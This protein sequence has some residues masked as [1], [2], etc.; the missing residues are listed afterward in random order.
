MSPVKIL[1]LGLLGMA[2]L[3]A[4]T[5]LFYLVFFSPAASPPVDEG[6]PIFT[7]AAETLMAQLTQAAADATGT[8][9]ALPPTWTPTLTIQVPTDT[10]RPTNT[11]LVIATNTPIFTPTSIPTLADR[12]ATPGTGGQ[13]SAP[14]GT[15]GTPGAYCNAAKFIDDVTIPDNTKVNPGTGFVKTWRLE[16]YGSCTWTTDY[17][18]VFVK[19]DQMSA[20]DE[21]PMPKVVKPGERVDISVTM[22]APINPGTYESYWKL[23]DASGVLF[24]TG[25]FAENSIW[26]IIQVKE[27]SSGLAFDF[28][29]GACAA[30]WESGAGTLPCPGKEGDKNGFVIPLANPQLENRNEDEPG[31]LTHPEMKDNGFISG[32]YPPFTVKKGDVFLADIGC[33]ADSD[34]CRVTFRL[35]YQNENDAVKK[36]GEWNEVSDGYLTSVNIDLSDLAGKTVEFILTVSANGSPTDDNAVWFVPQ[37]QRD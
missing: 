14:S 34:D 7:Q 12:T 4:L 11:P 29:S 22:I 19:G 31:L 26:A 35:D 13:P 36:L 15:P 18:L 37:I 24:G 21:V 17:S 27:V 9:E 32:S 3:V 16:N 23:A 5:V 8:A 10:P 6:A 30:R 20:P 25:T 33:A 1:I 2:A 28:A